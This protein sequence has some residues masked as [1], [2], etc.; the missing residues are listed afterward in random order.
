MSFKISILLSAFAIS[1][2]GCSFTP[3]ELRTAEQIMN[4]KP[5]S[6]LLILQHK[7]AKP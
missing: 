2:V 1:L 7:T 5:D 4:S 6:A 3:N